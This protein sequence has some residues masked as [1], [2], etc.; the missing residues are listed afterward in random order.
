VYQKPLAWRDNPRS[1]ERLR[2]RL[3]MSEWER[4]L[5]AKLSCALCQILTHRPRRTNPIVDMCR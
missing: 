5:P 2:K 4:T 1:A 3:D